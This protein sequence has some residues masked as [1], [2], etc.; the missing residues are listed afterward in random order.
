MLEIL[1]IA[2]LLGFLVSLKSRMGAA[3]P[4]F[5]YF[6]IWSAVFL[7]Y[8]FSSHTFNPVPASFFFLLFNAC[9]F[10]LFIL[11]IAHGGRYKAAIEFH[12]RKFKLRKNLVTLLQ[13]ACVVS[14]PFAYL[15]ASALAAGNDIFSV[16]GYIY[17]R[18]SMTEDGLGLG[19]VNYFSILSY[20]ICSI[21]VC[22]FFLDERRLYLT[23]AAVFVACFYAYINTGRTG[24]LLLTVLNV[25]PLVLRG[26]IRRRGILISAAILAA[27]FFLIAL[28]TAKGV[29]A[30]ASFGENIESLAFN[31]R[32]YTI[33]PTL[34]FS[35]LEN[36]LSNFSYGLNSFRFVLS[37]INSLGF[38]GFEPPAL[39]REYAFVPDATNVYTVY[40]VYF[41]DFAYIGIFLPPAF[42]IIHWVLYKRSAKHGGRW[43]F[44][45]AA[46]AYPLLMQFFSD[47]YFSLFSIWLQIAFW[48]WIFVKKDN[49]I[50]EN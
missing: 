32:A 34:A 26:A 49:S 43:I 33:A 28:M 15:K 25:I 3:N 35:W 30:E 39:I 13:A 1:I 29:S 37:L 24:V 2:N 36:T 10:A 7:G 27:M 45:Y 20:V 11:F 16:L 23:L 46:S 8:Y 22:Q 4:F 47:Q 21:R 9:V 41:R 14:L 12:N 38:D 6:A 31:L 48:Y 50:L 40:D 18:T 17:L 44:Y 42:L 19:P 5:I